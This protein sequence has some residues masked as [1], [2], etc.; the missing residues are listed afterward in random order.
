[1][2]KK[3]NT[4]QENVQNNMQNDMQ[5]MSKSRQN[6]MHVMKDVHKMLCYAECLQYTM[7]MRNM[8]SGGKRM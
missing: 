1:M 4:L 8:P 6:N 5:N 2:Q 7:D 3:Q